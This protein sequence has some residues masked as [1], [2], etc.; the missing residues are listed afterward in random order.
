M[1]G[2]AWCEVAR[3][4]GWLEGFSPTVWLLCAPVGGDGGQLVSDAACA[5][6]EEM[7]G[8]LRSLLFEEGAL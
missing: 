8:R 1:T 6:Y 3:I 4:V 2:G 7:V 5:E